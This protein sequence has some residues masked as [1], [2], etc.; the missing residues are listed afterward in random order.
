MTEKFFTEEQ[1]MLFVLLKQTKMD[2]EQAEAALCEL[3]RLGPVNIGPAVSDITGQIILIF[4]FQTRTDQFEQ[5]NRPSKN[6]LLNL[7]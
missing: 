1:I 3:E 2:S 5:E 4:F 7:L 6:Y